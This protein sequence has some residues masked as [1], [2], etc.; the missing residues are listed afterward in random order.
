MRQLK[1]LTWSF[2]LFL[3]G[4]LSL[5]A[6]NT[7]L[8]K[9]V[10]IVK[11]GVRINKNDDAHYLT[12]TNNGCYESDKNG[13]STSDKFLKFI[14]N[15]NN[16]HCYYGS[17]SFGNANYYFSNDFSRLNIKLNDDLIYVYQRELS[18]RTTASLRTTSPS[19]NGGG[20]VFVTPPP[21]V[22]GGTSG[23]DSNSSHS[24]YTKCTTCNGTG[25]CTGCNGRC[26]EW[27]NTGYY[28]GTDT[29][30]W[31]ECGSCRGSG[32]CAICFGRGKL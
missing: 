28:I 8:Y 15:E 22:G 3:L 25:V 21:V 5:I 12:F 19:S 24:L 10:M 13:Y 11:E 20:V 1:I 18:G 30:S 23:N 9:R 14:K 4:N 32:K 31:I 29:K 17:C 2:F 6:Q 26:G 27:R 7:Y 16:L